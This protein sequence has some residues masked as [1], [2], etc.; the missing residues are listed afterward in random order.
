MALTHYGKT[1]DNIV[2]LAGD[3]CPVRNQRSM[4]RI[5]RVLL[6]GSASH[7]FNLASN[8]ELGDGTAQSPLNY[9]ESKHFDEEG[10]NA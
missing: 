7:N 2:C 4:A 10:G 8:Q 9:Y 3:N 1:V 5:L 6:L